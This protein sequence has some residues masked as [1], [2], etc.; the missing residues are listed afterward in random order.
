LA[1]FNVDAMADEYDDLSD[2]K[3]SEIEQVQLI[4]FFDLH[5]EFWI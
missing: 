5:F 4:N 1:T 2:L 3:S